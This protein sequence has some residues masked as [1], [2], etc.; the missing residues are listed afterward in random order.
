MSVS[1]IAPLFAVLF[2]LYAVA[3]EP[4]EVKPGDTGQSDTDDTV[5][6]DDTGD[7]EAPPTDE[8]GDGFLSDED[9]DDTDPEVNPDADGVDGDGVDND[10]DGYVDEWDVCTGFDADYGTIQEAIDAAPDGQ[11]I[12]VCPGTWVESL[13]IANKAVALEASDGPEVTILTPAVEGPVVQVVAAQGAYVDGFTITGGT[14][15]EGAG[16]HCYNSNLA[17]NGNIFVDNTA[18]SNGAGVGASN[19]DLAVYG[20]A[21]NENVATSFGGGIYT[22]SN[23]AGLIYDNVFTSNSANYGGAIFT[24]YGDVN[25]ESNDIWDNYASSYGGGMYKYYGSASI[26][27]NDFMGNTVDE[28]EEESGDGG[29]LYAY[30]ASGEITGNTFTENICNNDGGAVYISVGS[31]HI[32]NNIFTGN[33]SYDDAGG[34]RLYVS[35]ALVEYNEFYSNEATDDGGGMKLS[36]SSDEVSNNYFEGNITGDAGGGLELDNETAWVEG[37]TFVDNQAYRGGGAHS[38]RTEGS[39]TITGNHFEGN[40]AEDCGGGMSMDND[41]YTVSYIQNTFIANSAN[42]GGAFCADLVYRDIDD[43][44]IID[45]YYE[46][47]TIIFTNNLVVDNTSGDDGG[48]FYFKVSTVTFTNNTVDGNYGPTGSAM[49]I[50]DGTTLAISN[51]IF[52]DNTGDQALYVEDADDEIE[53]PVVVSVQY[54]AFD[55]NDGNASNLDDPVGSDGNIEADPQYTD[56]AGGDYSLQSSSPCVDAGVPAITD[57]DGT[58]SDMGAY[59]GPYG[60]W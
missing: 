25:V 16:V 20:N 8:D 56:A 9:C 33:I 10:C 27:D 55:G 23:C 36:H 32:A 4:P 52:S 51:A 48:A 26:T 18:S 11:T 57:P 24:N 43:D 19:C 45:D 30:Y 2:G 38:W 37:N 7:P 49:A 60:A 3:C 53:E 59:G 31:Q 21:F 34:L 6:P 35:T 13:L 14:N 15:D 50:K 1:R 29:A 5:D 46:G 28:V 39:I 22:D 12:V 42:D 17:L 58:R 40:V 44:D 47:N 54:S 41:P